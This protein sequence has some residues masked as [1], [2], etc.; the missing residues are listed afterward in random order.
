VGRH[1]PVPSERR[2]GEEDAP[3]RR[4]H[5]GARGYPARAVYPGAALPVARESAARSHARTRARGLVAACRPRQ[6]PKNLLVL[7]VPAA[8]GKLGDGDV[9]A[10]T[11]AALAAFVMASSG[12]YLLNDAGDVEADRLH[13]IKRFR[14]IAAGELPLRAAVVLGAL[15]L[16]GGVAL[17]TAIRLEL[18]AVVLGYVV[19]TTLYSRRLK[20]VPIFDIA[21]VASGFFLRAVAG[22]V[23]ADIPISRWFLIVAGGGSLFLV[24]GKRYAELVSAGDGAVLTRAA[25]AEYSSEYLRALLSTT[26]AVTV[27]AYV[28]WSFEPHGGDPASRWTVL[29]AVPFVLG[30]MRY[31]LLVDQGHGEEPEEIVLGDRVLQG[32]GAAWLLCLAIGVIA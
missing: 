13:P 32:I 20:H 15:L 12:T 26:A 9:L 18:G 7:A 22:G 24:T 11:V 1:A 17:A 30:I 27:V 3:R 2:R 31:G 19:L 6:W 21:T 8:A 28:L 14:P 25:L 10:A 29:S 16:A 23:A 4:S 5:V